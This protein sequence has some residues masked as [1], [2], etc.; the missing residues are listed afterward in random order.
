MNEFCGILMGYSFKAI[1]FQ[2]HFWH[3]PV[4]LPRSQLNPLTP[5]LDSQEARIE[6][7][8][9]LCDKNGLF[10]FLEVKNAEGN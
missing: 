4:W 1:L 2:D 3:V 7:K 8:S 6:V 9:W 10:E 5:L